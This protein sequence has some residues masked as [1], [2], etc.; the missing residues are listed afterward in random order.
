[1]DRKTPLS[2]DQKLLKLWH[3]QF[4]QVLNKSNNHEIRISNKPKFIRH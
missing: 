1:L 4:V 3:K 2:R